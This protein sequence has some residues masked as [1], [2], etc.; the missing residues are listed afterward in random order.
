[1]ERVIIQWTDTAKNGL[2]ALPKKVR[3]GL[4]DKANELRDADDPTTCH[5]RLTGPLTGYFRIC[6]SRY[7]A[8]YTVERETLASG[9]ILQKVIIRFVA[10][11]KR[12]EGGKDDI[13]RFAMKL[14]DLGVIEAGGKQGG[15]EKPDKQQA[16][17][18][19]KGK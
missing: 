10:A 15:E 14:I 2:A 17:K 18:K 7:R 5:K 8:I 19:Q 4:L 11:G 13:Y 12:N 6:Y 9:D 1:M 3:R 16:V